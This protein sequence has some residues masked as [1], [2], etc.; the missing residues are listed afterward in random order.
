MANLDQII[1]SVLKRDGSGSSGESLVVAN[2][3]S[4]QKLFGIRAGVE[5]YPN[6]DDD[7]DTRG[8]FVQGLHSASKVDLYLDRFWDLLLC[9]GQILF[10]LR[11]TGETYRIYWYDKEQFRA[12]YNGDGDLQEV[13]IV[14]NY[15]V[16]SHI[17]QKQLKWLR[18]RITADKI[19]RSE[20]DTQPSFEGLD[21]MQW[22]QRE[23]ETTNTLGFI[24]CV[25]VKNY[26]SGPGQ[27]G[28][29]EFQWLKEQIESH[30]DMARAMTANLKFFGNPTLVSTRSSSEL[31]EVGLDEDG[32]SLQRPTLS[33]NGGWYGSSYSTRKSDPFERGMR[34]GNGVRVKRVIGNVQPDERFGYVAPDPTSPDHSRHLAEM[35]ESIHYALGGIDELG[36]RS[37]ATAYEMKTIYGKV[38]ATASKK[39]LHLYDHGLC[40]VFELAIAAEEKVFKDTLAA[41]LKKN[42]LEITDDF[43]MQLLEAGKIPKGVFGLPP[44]GD[45]TIKWRHTGP[46]FED[47]PRDLLDKSIV[48]RNLQELGVQSLEGLKFL[49]AD[50]TE[51]ELLNILSGGFPF[52]YVSEIGNTAGQMIN[53]LN[54]SLSLPH[55]DDPSLPFAAYVNF[56]PLIQ[57]TVDTLYRELNHGKQFDPADPNSLPG[58][59]TW[60]TPY[61]PTDATGTSTSNGTGST[62]TGVGAAESNGTGNNASSST[63]SASLSGSS[64]AAAGIQPPA[65]GQQQPVEGSVRE[66]G[67]APEYARPL[68]VPGGVVNQ[69]SV[70]ASQPPVQQW[71]GL[72]ESSGIPVDLLSYPSIIEQLFP[73]FTA[74]AK[75]VSSKRKRK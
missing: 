54:Q 34:T 48:V 50:K 27:D 65:V 41:A 2:H 45:R 4:Q 57:A 66:G 29:G 62:P 10:Y 5:F 9:G 64:L 72:P 20:S 19:Y 12:Y 7:W 22:T 33:S 44:L 75:R 43:A 31:T 74:A 32:I 24:P 73:T 61:L 51:K 52:R 15:K 21:N 25:V 58:K 42:T 59:P 13:V 49:F 36:L 17:D 67:V 46:V 11:P 53:L 3:L 38:A 56:A 55:P 14:Y 60:T 16:R 28:I 26:S 69:Q 70:S 47:S 35:R 37:G 1:E 23:E 68:P 71:G 63:A 6:Q 40:K 30:D 18:L 8:K 39:C